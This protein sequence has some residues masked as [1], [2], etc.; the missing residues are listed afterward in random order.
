MG[1]ASRGMQSLMDGWW[2]LALVLLAVLAAGLAVSSGTHART[3]RLN[4]AASEQN[5]TAGQA[6]GGPTLPEWD[7][8]W[9]RDLDPTMVGKPVHLP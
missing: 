5:M 8:E 3:G 4:P 7:W 9:Q 1:K 6:G 2:V